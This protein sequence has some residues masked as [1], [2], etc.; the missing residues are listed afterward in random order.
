MWS[1]EDGDD[2]ATDLEMETADSRALHTDT[3]PGINPTGGAPMKS[4]F[5]ALNPG[6]GMWPSSA[7]TKIAFIC[8]LL[9]SPFPWSPNRVDS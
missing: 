1:S 7:P 3:W 2:E 9:L 4:L 5:S 6:L 8:S